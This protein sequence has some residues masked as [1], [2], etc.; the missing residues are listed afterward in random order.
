[1]TLTETGLIQSGEQPSEHKNWEYTIYLY[2]SVC[3]EIVIEEKD[4]GDEDT[5]EDEEEE[6]PTEARVSWNRIYS[7]SQKKLCSVP[8][9]LCTYCTMLR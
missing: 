2:N 4:E 6:E 3:N 7:L 1:M 8:A 5:D 9:E